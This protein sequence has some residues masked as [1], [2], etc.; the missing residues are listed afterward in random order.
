MTNGE[1]QRYSAF[2][3]EPLDG[4]VY[5][6]HTDYLAA[7]QEAREAGMREAFE[8]SKFGSCVVQVAIEKG[9]P[10][11]D[12]VTFIRAAIRARLEQANG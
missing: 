5:V 8:V 4:G 3:N 1:I 6:L 2:D 10:T 11:E 7:I 12:I 9:R